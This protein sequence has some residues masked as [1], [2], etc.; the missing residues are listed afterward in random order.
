MT[1]F[2][3]VGVAVQKHDFYFI[4][5]VIVNIGGTYGQAIFIAGKF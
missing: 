4:S 5:G 2:H 1:Y 3:F